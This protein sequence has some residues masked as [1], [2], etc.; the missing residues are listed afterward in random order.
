MK[1]NV[2]VIAE[3]YRPNNK[4]EVP[5]VLRLTKNRK[6]KCFRLG[7][8]IDPKYWDKTKNKLK[9]NTPNREYIENLITEKT[10]KYQ[11]Q[12]LEFQS[13]DKD[14]SL[15][16]LIDTVEKRTKNISVEDYLNQIIQNLMSENRVG[17]ANHY[18]ALL[19]SLQKFCQLSQL[20]FVD[21]DN[22]FLNRYE[23][24]LSSLGNKGNT[25]NIKMRTLKA[26]FNKAIKANAVKQDYYP[27]NDYNV[28]KLKEDTAKR[29]ITKDEM[30]KIV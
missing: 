9:Q 29:S 11:R 6:R 26:T 15:N 12:I 20:L 17:N 7:I 18:K 2:E 24:H 27:F 13:I 22:S 8:T 21:I 25:I 4:G 28:S 16:K 14:F 23:N 3:T 30:L 1:A 19:S 5:L 10:L